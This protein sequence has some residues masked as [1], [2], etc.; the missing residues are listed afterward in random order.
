M[1]GIAAGATIAWLATAYRARGFATAR[2]D[3]AMRSYWLSLAA[4]AGS[5][6][7]ALPPVYESLDAILGVPDLSRLGVNG[8]AVAAVGCA[9]YG[10]LLTL[11]SGRF[12]AILRRAV[13]TATVVSV[14]AMAALFFRG[15]PATDTMNFYVYYGN[16]WIAAYRATYLADMTGV[17]AMLVTL[18]TARLFKERRVFVRIGFSLMA[19]GGISALAYL[20]NDAGLV[21][22]QLGWSGASWWGSPA[23][24]ARLIALA[25]V[26]LVAGGMTESAERALTT[27]RCHAALLQLRP[28]REAVREAMAGGVLIERRSFWRDL[29]DPRDSEFRMRMELREIEDALLRLSRLVPA[30]VMAEAAR[31]GRARFAAERDAAAF[32]EAVAIQAARRDP[33]GGRSKSRG[34]TRLNPDLPVWRPEGFSQEIQRF[35]RVSRFLSQADAMLSAKAERGAPAGTHPFSAG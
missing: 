10:A 25:V 9:A 17:A 29:L 34:E 8:L 21:A 23:D 5:L 31:V 32:L 35:K 6:T 3:P 28:L 24:E 2:R 12:G 1:S 14:T 18:W 16:P 15:A 22:Q 27:L 20:T 7:L 30:A 4:L 19:A 13:V 33:P 11:V 26:L